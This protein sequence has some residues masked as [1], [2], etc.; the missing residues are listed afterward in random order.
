MSDVVYYTLGTIGRMMT[1]ASRTQG[2]TE[3][4]IYRF[5]REGK[6]RA[7]RVPANLRGCGKY[8]LWVR[9]SDLIEFL[10]AQGF[11]TEKMFDRP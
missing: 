9:E 1:N 11:D 3:E 5:V 8:G 6:L 2:F 7:E 10:E 4:G